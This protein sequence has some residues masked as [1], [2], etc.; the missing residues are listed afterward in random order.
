M[1]LLFAVALIFFQH[2]KNL[3]KLFDNKENKIDLNEAVQKDKDFAKEQK[4]KREKIRKLKM[5]KLKSND[6]TTNDSA[7]NN[8]EVVAEEN[9]LK[10]GNK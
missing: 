3:Q 2:R 5:K 9:S 7:Q 8:D 10:D 6:L 1:L 4:E